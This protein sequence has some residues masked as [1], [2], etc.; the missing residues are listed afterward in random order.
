MWLSYRNE[1]L[2]PIYIKIENLNT[3]KW[4][5]PKR[6]NTFFFGFIIIVY[7]QLEDINN[8]YNDLKAKIYHISS[9]TILEHIYFS[10]I[11]DDFI[12]INYC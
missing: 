4:Q 10:L 1:I 2:L 5:S 3:K 7:K 11:F 8:K 12:K 6:L 9:K